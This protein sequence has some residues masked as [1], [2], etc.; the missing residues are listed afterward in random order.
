[1]NR[2]RKPFRESENQPQ[3]V[4][5]PGEAETYSARMARQE[6]GHRLSPEERDRAP[7][8]FTASDLI[9]EVAWL[10]EWATKYFPKRLVHAMREEADALM[11]KLETLG[12]DLSAA[13]LKEL[14][15]EVSCFE[16][17]YLPDRRSQS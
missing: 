14:A 7:G 9:D 12:N 11:I 13:D 15:D 3:T 4:H 10:K 2:I 5:K 8:S 6:V 1:M 17:N 16:K